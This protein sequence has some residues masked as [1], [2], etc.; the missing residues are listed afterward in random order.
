MESTE[1]AR[2]LAELRQNISSSRADVGN[3]LQPRIGA[4]LNEMPSPFGCTRWQANYGENKRVV[5][6]LFATGKIVY[7]LQDRITNTNS[8][9]IQTSG[10]F[11]TPDMEPRIGSNCNYF[12]LWHEGELDGLVQ[13]IKEHFEAVPA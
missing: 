5:L 2:A 4:I 13:K 8:D 10:Y 7:D 11:P 12:D 9:P 3:Y 6:D 1:I